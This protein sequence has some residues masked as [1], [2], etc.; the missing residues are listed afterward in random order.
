MSDSY[1]SYK[2]AFNN[3]EQFKESF[4]EPEPA[5]VGYVFIGNHVPW[6]NESN[7]DDISDTVSNEKTIWDN[8][9][10]AKKVTGNDVEL[11]LPKVTWTANTKYRHYD[12]TILLSELITANA[13]QNLQPIYVMNSERNVYKCLSNNRGGL[14]TLEPTGKN[15]TA[16]GVISK[17]DGYLW[18]YMFNVK[19]SNKFLSNV[20]IPAPISTGKLDYDVTSVTT[21]DGEITKIVVTNAG[22][23]YVHSNIS[24]GAYTSGCTILTVSNT[25]N[26]SA[27]MA[28]SGNGI[29]GDTHLNI[30]DTVNN[31]ITISNATSGSGGGV[32][33]T[34]SV[35]TRIYLDG[36]GT[37]F[38]ATPV[39]S[40]NTIL[41]VNVTSYGRNF[42]RGNVLI[43]GT[44]TN[45][46][47]R[48]VIPPKFGHG[49]NSAKELGG[50]N[51]MVS[52]RIG[53]VDSTEGGIISANTT[54][55]QYGLLRDPYKYGQTTS[56]NNTSANSVIAQTTKVTLIA[57]SSYD[58]NEYVYQGVSSGNASF[59]G[60]VNNQTTNQVELTKVKGTLEVGTVLK[61]SNT[62][63][64]GRTVVGS[65]SPEFQPYTG[66]I[67]Y[68]ENIQK[69]DRI[70]GQAENIKLVIKF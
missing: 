25:L 16:N 32:S 64:S 61:G 2:T 42:N 44:G 5:T 8:M 47:A 46:A 20:W 57:G 58:L 12:D 27:N 24:V 43:Y 54:F 48:A 40:G 60:Y 68:V 37:G 3:A 38:V 26:L 33:N 11:V 4:Y 67:L 59:S 18:K 15:L 36:D 53:D 9:Y 13:S 1:I 52:V 14:S 39:L 35:R 21:I 45:A 51:V 7:P 55:R 70:D 63:P 65:V 22:T 23:G 6:S 41:D 28:V 30:V 31:K 56:A 29:P 17:D 69:V 62:N 10:A 50:K 66:D 34:L 49:Y 19:A